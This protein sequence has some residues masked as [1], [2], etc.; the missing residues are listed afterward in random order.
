MIIAFAGPQFAA[1]AEK[2]SNDIYFQV[3]MITV[4]GLNKLGRFRKRKKFLGDHGA[5]TPHHL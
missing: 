3:G 5:D 4:M 2:F 1:M